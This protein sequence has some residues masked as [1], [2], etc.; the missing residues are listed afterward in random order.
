MRMDKIVKKVYGKSV[1][2]GEESGWIERQ[3]KRDEEEKPMTE[4]AIVTLKGIANHQFDLSKEEFMNAMNNQLAG[5]GFFMCESTEDITVV[6]NPSNCSFI[7]IV[8]V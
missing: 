4:I 6:I 3:V 8:E 2:S 7:E 1:N 5:Q